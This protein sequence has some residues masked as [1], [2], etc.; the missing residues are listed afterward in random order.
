MDDWVAIIFWAV[1]IVASVV[2]K[3]MGQAG[4][5]NAPDEQDLK[6]LEEFF[7]RQKSGSAAGRSP[8]EADGEFLP[9]RQPKPKRAKKRPE[10]VQPQ[11]RP[12]VVAGWSADNEPDADDGFQGVEVSG[13][14][15]SLIRRTASEPLARAVQPRLRIVI[16]RQSMLQTIVMNEILQRYDLMRLSK[17]LPRRYD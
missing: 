5:T 4:T 14:T 10:P 8:T 11:V 2:S 1:V 17:I 16:N 3:V 15:R 6:D 12:P 13:G 9:Q 7:T